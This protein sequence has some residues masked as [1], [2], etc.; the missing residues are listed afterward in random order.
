MRIEWQQVKNWT[1]FCFVIF[2]PNKRN[3]E[4]TF[5]HF[6]NTRVSSF[7]TAVHLLVAYFLFNPT[8]V[9]AGQAEQMTLA[10]KTNSLGLSYKC[11]SDKE[12]FYLGENKEPQ[13]Q[14]QKKEFSWTP[15][16][17]NNM[18]LVLGNYDAILWIQKPFLSE[19]RSVAVFQ[20][21]EKPRH[22]HTLNIAKEYNL[23][24][25]PEPFSQNISV[26]ILDH[27][28]EPIHIECEISFFNN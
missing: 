6:I 16:S 12:I 17:S 18:N 9:L 11:M 24:V 22:D 19:K 8:S 27:H 25:H 23:G 7:L 28:D 21:K 3:P 10:T 1:Q 14:D 5:M 4:E 20:R 15:Q 2:R 13:I 26:D